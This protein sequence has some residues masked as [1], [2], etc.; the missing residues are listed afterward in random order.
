MPTHLLGPPQTVY[1]TGQGP[2]R[3]P[4]CPVRSDSRLFKAEEFPSSDVLDRPRSLA[5]PDTGANAEPANREI[6]HRHRIRERAGRLAG[7]SSCRP[8][9]G[10]AIPPFV[11]LA[12]IDR[13]TAN[14]RP[15]ARRRTPGRIGNGRG[16]SPTQRVYRIGQGPLALCAF[17]S[18][19]ERTAW[20]P[21]PLRRQAPDSLQHPLRLPSFNSPRFFANWTS[22]SLHV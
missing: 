3:S 8:G 20:R 1:R 14:R 7:W 6:R 21:L 10:A 15:A 18:F 13:R 11:G 5:W 12:T 17:D 19:S 4:P 9:A 16:A 2:L 22:A